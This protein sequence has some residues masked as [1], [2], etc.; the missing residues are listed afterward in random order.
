M[1]CGY[2]GSADS[3][4]TQGVRG[5]EKLQLQYNKATAV[6]TTTKRTTQKR[7]AFP[8]AKF[9]FF[10]SILNLPFRSD[11]KWAQQLFASR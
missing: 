6:V 5:K 3:G 8:F 9:L 1:I 11:A 10:F 7:L 4:E 2:G